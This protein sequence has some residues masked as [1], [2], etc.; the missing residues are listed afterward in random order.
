[1]LTKA[2]GDLTHQQS[3]RESEAHWTWRRC[4]RQEAHAGSVPQNTGA[5]YFTMDKIRAA[6]WPRSLPRHAYNHASL[7]GRAVVAHA[8]TCTLHSDQAAM[9]QRVVS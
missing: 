2:H 9:W 8:N 5:A 7:G 6:A 1:M 3:Q 4:G